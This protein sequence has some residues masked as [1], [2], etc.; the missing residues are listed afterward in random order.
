M[1][2]L[3]I[4][5]GVLLIISSL[6][7]IIMVMLQESKGKGL[8]GAVGGGETQVNEARTRTTDVILAKYTKYAAIIFFAVTL[9]V[10]LFSVFGK[11]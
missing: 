9:A 2:T 1:S 10:S 11:K 4:V 3:E 6:V 8:S 5:G 7:I